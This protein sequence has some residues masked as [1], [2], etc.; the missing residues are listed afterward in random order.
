[1]RV[2][3]FHSN[4]ARVSTHVPPVAVRR[5]PIR[6]GVA[7]SVRQNTHRG[8]AAKTRPRGARLPALIVAFG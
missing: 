4:V 5:P 7:A 3:E 2:L 1:M 8:P 6:A